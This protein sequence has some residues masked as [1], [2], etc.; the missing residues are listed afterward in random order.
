MILIQTFFF[1][2]KSSLKEEHDLS[3]LNIIESIK[4]AGF[5]FSFEF[6]GPTCEE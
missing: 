4:G 5:Q 3:E 6:I 1:V 2:H